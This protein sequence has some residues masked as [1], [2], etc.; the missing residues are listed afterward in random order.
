MYCV[1]QPNIIG[2]YAVVKHVNE[3]QYMPP[4]I[5]SYI[6]NIVCYSHSQQSDNLIEIY[7]FYKRYQTT[8]TITYNHETIENQNT[9]KLPA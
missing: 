2:T 4:L 7:F 3:A 8:T 1:I 9:G 5:D 6:S